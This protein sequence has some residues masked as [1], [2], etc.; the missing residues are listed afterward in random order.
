MKSE[1]DMRIED[2]L[3]L[4]CSTEKLSEE[5]S[6]YCSNCKVHTE[7][8][9]TLQ[10][11]SFPPVLV[12]HLKRFAQEEDGYFSEKLQT[13]INFPLEGLDLRQ[14]ALD[15]ESQE[16]A[17]YDL[18]CVTNHYGGIGSGHYTCYTRHEPDGTWHEFDDDAVFP[19]RNLAAIC[20]TAAYVLFYLRRD[21]RPARWGEPREQVIMQDSGSPDY[22][23]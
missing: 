8:T 14:Y 17:I 2:C 23:V 15:P 20:S 21:F 18:C 9:K 1:E 13:Q 6:W 7:A 5:D 3:E 16:A 4:L 10:I 22:L 19:V 11:W 12:L